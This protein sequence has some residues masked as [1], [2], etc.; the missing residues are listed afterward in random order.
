MR[1]RTF[2]LAV[3]NTS[4]YSRLSADC[5]QL[6]KAALICRRG[7][8]GSQCL[9][10]VTGWHTA[11]PTAAAFRQNAAFANIE[12]AEQHVQLTLGA[13]SVSA[14][15]PSPQRSSLA[16]SASPAQGLC[17]CQRR[18][19]SLPP[20]SP[21]MRPTAGRLAP[22]ASSSPAARA[23]RRVS[24]STLGGWSLPN[25]STRLCVCVFGA[26]KARTQSDLE[27][28]IRT[29]DAGPAASSRVALQR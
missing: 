13:I 10:A 20:A 11:S 9:P 25:H 29:C 26:A 14:P 7:V 3:G 24:A 4:V 1:R 28:C 17:S 21:G 19:P 23:S 5:R 8:C 22:P 18:A 12:Q 16:A 27:R 15:F 2:P 6:G